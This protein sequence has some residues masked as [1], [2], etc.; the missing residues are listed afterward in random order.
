MNKI[1]HVLFSG[2]PKTNLKSP[3]KF[4]RRPTYLLS[5]VTHSNK[6][7]LPSFQSFSKYILMTCPL[8]TDPFR[9]HS[10]LN[11]QPP[12]PVTIKPKVEILT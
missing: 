1:K 9:P 4:H 3:T 10:S 2:Q 8:K 7:F 11:Y 5:R 12:S 6:E